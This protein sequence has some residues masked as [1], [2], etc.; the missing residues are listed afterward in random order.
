M[1]YPQPTNRAYKDHFYVEDKIIARYKELQPR[2]HLEIIEIIKDEFSVS[3]LRNTMLK[4]KEKRYK[5][6]ECGIVFIGKHHQ[7]EYCDKCK[8]LVHKAKAKPIESKE[9]KYGCIYNVG[10]YGI[11]DLGLYGCNVRPSD[12]CIYNNTSF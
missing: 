1:Q 3:S 5:C 7:H 10:I 12:R 4:I 6:K 11:S 2:T 9:E 8:G